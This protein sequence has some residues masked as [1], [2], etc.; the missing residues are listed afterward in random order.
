MAQPHC[1]LCVAN[2]P[3][4]GDGRMQAAAAVRRNQRRQ[5][6][7]APTP[8]ALAMQV[9]LMTAAPAFLDLPSYEAIQVTV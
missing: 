9:L 2:G 3:D 6:L 7:P 4:A 5:L 1:T 8:P